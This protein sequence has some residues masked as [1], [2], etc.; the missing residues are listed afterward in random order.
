[1]IYNHGN[2]EHRETN[3]QMYEVQTPRTSIATVFLSKMYMIKEI[4]FTVGD[5]NEDRVAQTCVVR[6]EAEQKIMQVYENI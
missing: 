5:K 3:L 2:W 4:S 1:M 6:T